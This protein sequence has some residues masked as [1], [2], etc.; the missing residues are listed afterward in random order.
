MKRLLLLTAVSLAAP[1][2]CDLEQLTAEKV[3][4]GTLLATPEITVSPAAFGAGETEAT[5]TIPA[6]TEALVLFGE[7]ETGGTLIPTSVSGATVH[8]QPQGGEALPLSEEGGGTYRRALNGENAELVYQQSATYDFVATHGG[9]QFIG[10]VE[11]APGREAIAALH[12]PA[13]VVFHD[14]N[15]AFTLNRPA[16]N[17]NEAR[18][19]AFVSV[20]PIS[21]DGARGEATYTNSPSTPLEYIEMATLPERWKTDSVT[22]PGTAFPERAQTYLV[23]LQSVR[24]GGPKSSNLW[25]GST[26]LVGTADVGVVRTNP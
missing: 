20:Y 6:H 15:T 7:R 23:V 18:T 5:V 2:A 10:R 17:A 8:I 13:G 19:V 25:F 9:E 3:M 11:N 22:I 26:L 14:A 16:L 24:L 12:P 1:L 21:A 4:V